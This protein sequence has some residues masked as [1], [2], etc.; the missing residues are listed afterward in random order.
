MPYELASPPT[1]DIPG[2]VA[3]C[4]ALTD[5]AGMGPDD[6][7]HLRSS[8]AAGP[9]RWPRLDCRRYRR[10][11]SRLRPC[12]SIG[13]GRGTSRRCRA[14]WLVPS[15]LLTVHPSYPADR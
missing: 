14:A 11:W 8:P 7:R 6:V 9:E 4:V 10:R 15:E 1:L 5:R 12:S 3:V 2:I 13:P